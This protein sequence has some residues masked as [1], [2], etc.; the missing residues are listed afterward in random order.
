[1]EDL[2]QGLVLNGHGHGPLAIA[3]GERALLSAWLKQRRDWLML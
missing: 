3:P 2:E 1:M